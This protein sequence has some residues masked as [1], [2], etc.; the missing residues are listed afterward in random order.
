MRRVPLGPL[1]W[2]IAAPRS[3]VFDIV[4]APFLGRTPRA[5]A[6]K[7]EVR[8]R[9]RDAVVAAHFTRVLGGIRVTTVEEVTFRRPELVA[10]RLLSGPV[11]DVTET[12]ELSEHEERH[13]SC[14]AASSRAATGCGRGSSRAAG[15]SRSRNRSPRS[16]PKQ[17][18]AH[19]A[20]RA[21]T[22]ARHGC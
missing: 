15:G 14:G 8:S 9:S 13:D 19:S 12:F 22:A 2:A 10:F 5:L 17:N 21:R 7:L 20:E 6:S 4:A 16:R 3:L 18:A 1:E 11:A